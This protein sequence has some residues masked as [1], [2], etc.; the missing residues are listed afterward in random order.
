[1]CK[2][3]RF[4][5]IVCP[6]NPMHSCKLRKKYRNVFTKLIKNVAHS[7]GLLSSTRKNFK[8]FRKPLKNATGDHNDKL[9]IVY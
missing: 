3:V 5:N 2:R 7:G 8:L 9:Q 6:V 4:K 1:M